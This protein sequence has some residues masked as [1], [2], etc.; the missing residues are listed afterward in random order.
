[1][2][3]FTDAINR[4]LSDQNWYGALCLSLIMPDICG[5]IAYPKLN[6]ADRYKTWYNDYLAQYYSANISGTK[7]IFLT[8]S[9]CYALRCAL[10][11]TGSDNIT[12]Q[13]AREIL[14][15]F[16]FL[17]TG[18]HCIKVNNVLALNVKK[19]CE[20]IIRALEAWGKDMDADNE[21]KDKINNLLRIYDKGFSPQSGVMIDG[22]DE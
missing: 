13:R 16:A 1:M 3:R 2:R 8:A 21:A 14:E 11:H 6:T 4:C 22:T 18:S 5:K 20:D 9:D 12:D 7:V 10:L 19:F 15:R 17:T